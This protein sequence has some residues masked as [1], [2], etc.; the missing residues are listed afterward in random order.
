MKLAA[1]LCFTLLDWPG[2]LSRVE[3]YQALIRDSE[4][5]AVIRG[6]LNAARLDKDVSPTAWH[7]LRRDAKVALN[8]KCKKGDLQPVGGDECKL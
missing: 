7:A 8:R 1:L 5:V 3:L 6:L 2:V 4:Q